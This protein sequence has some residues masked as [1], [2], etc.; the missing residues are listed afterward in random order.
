MSKWVEIFLWYTCHLKCKF[1]FQKD[2]RE[3]SPDFIE[4]KEVEKIIYT[5]IKTS[6]F[7]VFSW[8]EAL[9]D[10]NLLSYIR[11]C[12]TVWYKDIR[13]HTNGLSFASDNLL[14]KFVDAWMNGVV[15]S[16]HGYARVHDILV[17]LDGAFK[18]VT[19]TL[20]NLGKVKK[21]YPHFVIDTNTVVSP[22]NRGNLFTLF[23]FLS[24]FPI[25]RSQIVQLYSLFLFSPQEKKQLY[26]KY[27]D[28]EK[29]L[30]KILNTIKM[31]IT[32]ENFP[33][34]KVD[35]KYWKYIEER[36]RYNNDAYGNMWEWLEESST[37]FLENCKS[38]C[39]KDIC[40]G[41]PKDYIQ[42]YPKETFTL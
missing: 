32:L 28:F 6:D 40:T 18:K 35:K 42:V 39:K 25:T 31:N 14:R 34:C 36:Q 17:S 1:C 3:T 13:V 4:R 38:C 10:K 11:L 24:R 22:Y 30:W 16:I 21:Q 37:T 12:K 29:E 41:V 26:V 19:R 15:V 27:E 23:S 2:L 33:F 5:G 8:G 9:L 7:I 20:I